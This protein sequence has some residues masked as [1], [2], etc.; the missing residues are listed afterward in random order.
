M[1]YNL[2]GST[3][4]DCRR[5]ASLNDDI[6][7]G[8]DRANCFGYFSESKDFR[9][10]VLEYIASIPKSKK[11][12]IHVDLAGRAQA[13][14]FGVDI[15]YSFAL[16]K[17]NGKSG[18]R[19]FIFFQ[20][21]FFNGKDFVRFLNTLRER[22]HFPSFVTFAPHAGFQEIPYN[23][24]TKTLLGKRFCQVVEIMS[25][26]GLLYMERPFAISDTLDF[27]KG[28]KQGEYGRSMDVKRLSRKMGCKVQ[29]AE[30]VYGPRFLV[31]KTRLVKNYRL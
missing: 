14:E 9:D 7:P 12:I 26:E 5:V 19:D 2:I 20:G 29:M 11:P 16:N 28:L 17:N 4:R 6:Y 3:L 23:Y 1:D 22:K 27:F 15:S 24:V 30:S 8:C 18:E 10:I 13:F 25:L 21:D 31:Q